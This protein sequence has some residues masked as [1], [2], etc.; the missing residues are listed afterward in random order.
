M[1][2]ASLE[3]LD[4]DDDDLFTTTALPSPFSP[5]LTL[6]AMLICWALPAVLSYIAMQKK[7][8]DN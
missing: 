8:R 6:L 4:D 7:A 5:L 3:P 1:S 2:S